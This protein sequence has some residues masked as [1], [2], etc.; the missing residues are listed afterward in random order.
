MKFTAKD[1]RE[2]QKINP[3]VIAKRYINEYINVAIKQRSPY[4]KQSRF[5]GVIDDKTRDISFSFQ[6][7]YSLS[8]INFDATKLIFDELIKHGYDIQT[9]F[10][11]TANNRYEGS[12]YFGEIE[13]D[14][15]KADANKFSLDTKE[16]KMM[17]AKEAFDNFNDKLHK[18]DF[19]IAEVIVPMIED[20]A[21]EQTFIELPSVSVWYAG[22]SLEF[23]KKYNKY[24]YD[25]ELTNLI[26]D[27]LR[28]N[29]FDC[30]FKFDTYGT[31]Y[32][33]GVGKLV[34]RWD[35]Q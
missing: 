22:E 13:I 27:E 25:I 20:V 31:E 26:L 3:K 18:R 10:K 8:R 28:R 2:M 33:N 34:I 11:I 4:F 5:N 24:G 12:C 30:Q 16:A 32:R 35:N 1:A 23:P 19:F 15:S 17:T 9:E 7:E 6:R 21:C 29:G 14:W